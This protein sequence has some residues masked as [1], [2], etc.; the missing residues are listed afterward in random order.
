MCTA[1]GNPTPKIEWLKDGMSVGS[2]GVFS[3]VVNRNHSGKYWC[4]ANNGL[5]AAVNASAELD[6]QCEYTFYD[7]NPVR[8]IFRKGSRKV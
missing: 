6:V 3:F 5:S 1:T 7:N 8:K 4:S 2:G